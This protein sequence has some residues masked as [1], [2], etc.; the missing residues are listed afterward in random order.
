[1]NFF[2][3]YGVPGRGAA[4]LQRQQPLFVK[5]VARALVT[6]SQLVLERLISNRIGE[7]DLEETEF[8]FGQPSNFS[9]I[10]AA[11]EP[12]VTVNFPDETPPP[13]E[14]EVIEYDEV[15]RQYETVRVENPDDEDQY[16]EEERSLK[17]RFVRQ[18]DGKFIQLNLRYD[19]PA[20]EV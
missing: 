6:R 10:A 2:P 19:G 3:K 12:Q 18:S 15:W 5:H 7:S 1:M 20:T 8:V 13:D 17:V 4:I 11:E 14:V 9:L 16:I